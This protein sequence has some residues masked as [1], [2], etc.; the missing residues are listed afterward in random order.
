MFDIVSVY[1]G[2]TSFSSRAA[3]LKNI[4]SNEFLFQNSRLTVNYRETNDAK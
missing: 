3:A 4:Y 2:R 1:T